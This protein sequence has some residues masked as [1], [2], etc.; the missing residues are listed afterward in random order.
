M[1]SFFYYEWF[2]NKDI[3]KHWFKQNDNNDKY[4]SDKYGDL[5]DN[6][7]YDNN[8]EKK[9]IIQIL[10]YD[11]LTRHYYRNGYNKHIITYFNRK[12]LE[13]A[14][15]NNNSDFIS[16]LN[17]EE[18]MFYMLVYRHTNIKEHL[19]YVMKEIWR[20]MPLIPSKNFIRAT[21]ERAVFKENLD[22]YEKINDDLIEFDKSIL[23]NN[24]S[25]YIINNK[26]LNIGRFENIEDDIIIVSLS[27][28][29]DS[30]VCLYNIQYLYS[31]TKRIVAIH[32]NYNNRKETAEEVKYLR[33]I[34]NILNVE[35]YVRKIDEINR[36]LCMVND[37][38]DVYEDYTKKVRYN[39]YK[40]FKENPTVILGHNKDDC[41]ENILTNIAYSNKYENLRGIEYKTVIDNITFIR[42]LIE[43]PK[44]EIYKFANIHNLPYLRNSTPNWCQRGKIRYE[45]LPALEK[46][47]MRIID[48]LFNLSD[49]L[50]N[51]NQ[52]LEITLDNFK[53]NDKGNINKLNLSKLYWKYGIFKIYKIF[54]SNKSLKSLMERLENWKNKYDKID[55]NKK[56]VIIIKK[57]IEII[58]IKRLN[59]N[60]EYF[61]NNKKLI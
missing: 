53:D 49:I 35:L 29:V 24:S 23:E 4:L 18:W 8:Y 9:E 55:V 58:L 45:I 47:D 10:I 56:T 57:D 37:L 51:Y 21:Y 17:N 34:C 61:F 22:K 43:V 30:I 15:R 7:N 26:Q 6:N 3:R 50:K 36:N 28:G 11:Q 40:I 5:I 12:A 32:I 31:K 44:S 27:G 1:I 60:Y 46:W 25:L 2:N 16:K 13:I 42:P 59:N 14:E 48:G 41:F 39:S 33:C 52:L 19:I 38:R 20:K 54:I